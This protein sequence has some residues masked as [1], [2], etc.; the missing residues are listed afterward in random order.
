MTTPSNKQGRECLLHSAPS[1]LCIELSRKP[2]QELKKMA[3]PDSFIRARGPTPDRPSFVWARHDG[4]RC[5][6]GMGFVGLLHQGVWA[7]LESPSSVR[8]RHDGQRW[9]WHCSQAELS[10]AKSRWQGKV[11]GVNQS[12]VAGSGR[13]WSQSH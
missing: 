11:T 9:M 3:S 10:G 13:V 1:N 7:L 12:G 4:Q 2:P 6:A 5:W 8:A